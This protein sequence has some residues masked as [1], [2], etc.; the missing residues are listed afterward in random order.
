MEIAIIILALAL[1][2]LI[3]WGAQQRK[4]LTQAEQRV[5]EAKVAE[6]KAQ[7]TAGQLLERLTL[8]ERTIQQMKEQAERMT[9][10]NAE[11][12]A[13]LGLAEQTLQQE[14]TKRQGQDEEMAARFKL[15]AAEVIQERSAALDQRSSE[16]L[17]P[18][19]ED[20]KRFT[21]RVEATYNAE[22]R[23]R[24]SLQE[25]IK[26][27]VARSLQLGQEADQLSRA[28]RGEA[29][30]QGNW[31]EMI[32]E[33]IL[34]G[35]GLERGKEYFVQES[36]SSESGERLIPDVIVRYPNGGSIVIDSKVSLKAY[37]DYVNASSEDD[38]RTYAAQ[39]VQSLLGHIKGLS[40]KKYEEVVQDSAG[41]VML[42]VPSEPAYA[43]AVNERPTIWEEAY[44][45]NV[46]LMNGSNLIAA[47]RMAL[48]LWQRD[49]QIRNVEKIVD[50][51]SRMYDTF[52]LHTERLMDAERHIVKASESIHDAKRKLVDGNGNIAKRFEN[53]RKLGLRI[54]RPLP[55]SILKEVNEDAEE[56]PASDE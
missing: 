45:Q 53:L 22:A 4:Q 19:R 5:L 27:L 50:E 21:E 49:R 20:L 31:G 48:E 51:A 47:L 11:L 40:G 24:F 14:R 23:E 2:L 25:Q 10:R 26:E 42:F 8:A 13:Q 32:L 55:E 7:E 16:L 1:I 34:E 15:L 30:V 33:K 9:V 12:S 54:K 29:K 38:R 44:R 41:F 17:N 46:I 18:L 35:S 6:A 28:L 56:L 43:L 52:V 37:T 3:V 39:H 36:I